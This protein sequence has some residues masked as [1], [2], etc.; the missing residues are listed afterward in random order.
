M[1]VLRTVVLAAVISLAM[2]SYS[3][4]AMRN[5]PFS[6]IGPEPIAQRICDKFFVIGTAPLRSGFNLFGIP[7]SESTHI[8]GIVPIAIAFCTIFWASVA[9]LIVMSISVAQRRTRVD[10]SS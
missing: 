3:I 6:R 10:P 8:L 9:G 7:N 4:H 1:N 2:A 5:A